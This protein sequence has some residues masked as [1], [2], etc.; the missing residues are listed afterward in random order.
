MAIS[1]AGLA[2]AFEATFVAGYANNDL[3]DKIAKDDDDASSADD[4]VTETSM[5][6]VTTP[7]GATSSFSGPARGN[8][9]GNKAIISTAL[10]ACFESMNSMSEGGNEKFAQDF[11]DAIHSY[12]SSGSISV[13]LKEPFISGSG[14]G[15]IA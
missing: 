8:F 7:S 3:A 10:K 2:A 13:E 15:G 6:I 4:T 5:G 11:A 14:S 12:M 1:E 9:A